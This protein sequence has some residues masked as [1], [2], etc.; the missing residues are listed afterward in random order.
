MAPVKPAV[1]IL[2]S[3]FCIL[4]FPCWGQAATQ[5]ISRVL[6]KGH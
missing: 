1:F 6:P 3:A 5:I 2:H 4:H